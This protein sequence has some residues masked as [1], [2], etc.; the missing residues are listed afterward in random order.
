MAFKILDKIFAQV[1]L[2]FLF[3]SNNR[4]PQ[5]LAIT[6]CLQIK[7]QQQQVHNHV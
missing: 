5:Q 4:T 7:L 1:Y 2:S 6:R 3:Q